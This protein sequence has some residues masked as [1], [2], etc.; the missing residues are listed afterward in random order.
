MNKKN[1]VGIWLMFLSLVILI[2]NLPEMHFLPLLFALLL[3]CFGGI[4]LIT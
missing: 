3:F 1:R 2:I 4:F